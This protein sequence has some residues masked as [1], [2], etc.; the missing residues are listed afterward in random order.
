MFSFTGGALE[1]M[2]VDAASK[3]QG[4]EK[5]CQISL[6]LMFWLK[7]YF[8]ISNKVWALFFFACIFF[9]TPSSPSDWSSSAC[10]ERTRLLN[11]CHTNIDHIQ[12]SHCPLCTQSITH[13]DRDANQHPN[14]HTR[15]S[16][17]AAPPCATILYFIPPQN[18][19]G[20]EGGG[21]VWRMEGGGGLQQELEWDCKWSLNLW[22]MSSPLLPPPRPRS[23]DPFRV[24]LEWI[25][26]FAY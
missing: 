17:R 21:V 25:C 3:H 19:R 6:I 12:S 5:H 16:G 11:L 13:R 18:G 20:M 22:V 26:G 8:Q 14:T 10:C 2:Q 4:V 15:R 24:T 7:V 1:G 23:P 9:S